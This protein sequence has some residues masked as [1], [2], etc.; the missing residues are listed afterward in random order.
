MIRKTDITENERYIKG[1]RQDNNVVVG[2]YDL[3]DLCC[4]LS[5]GVLMICKKNR[6]FFSL[7]ME[8]RFWRRREYTC[9]EAGL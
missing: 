6:F 3:P 1:G 9:F 4:I 2:C 7:R 5:T 8:K